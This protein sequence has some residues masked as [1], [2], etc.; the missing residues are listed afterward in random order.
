MAAGASPATFATFA[1]G[2]FFG[3]AVFFAGAAF[4][5]AAAALAAGDA[6]AAVFFAVWRSSDG[7]AEAPAA[8]EA[9]AGGFRED[10]AGCG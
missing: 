6:F 2:V 8:D 3:A 7:V 1:T 9:A 10:C 4:F 5:G